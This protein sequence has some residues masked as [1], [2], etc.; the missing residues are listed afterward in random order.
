MARSR[1]LIISTD[2]KKRHVSREERDQLLLSGV[3]K[4]VGPQEYRSTLKPIRMHS[5]GELEKLKGE[6]N[7]QAGLLRHFL[8]GSFIFEQGETRKREMLET[9][10]AMVL[11]LKNARQLQAA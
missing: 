10:E 4:Q 1:Y 6:M 9:V 3:L 8:P 7:E 5:M 2:G 11:R